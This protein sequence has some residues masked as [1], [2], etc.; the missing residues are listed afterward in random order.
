MYNLKNCVYNLAAQAE[1]SAKHHSLMFC[2]AFV[3][4]LNCREMLLYLCFHFPKVVSI[5][6]LLT[7]EAVVTNHSLFHP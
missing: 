4:L 5:T 7:D 1:I 3:F 2:W 6:C